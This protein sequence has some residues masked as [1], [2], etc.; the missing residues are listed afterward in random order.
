MSFGDPPDVLLPKV[1][2]WAGKKL[3]K[4]IDTRPEH[5]R[6][7]IMSGRVKEISGRFATKES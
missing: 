5:G 4:H 3:A 1:S 6:V 2:S 7:V